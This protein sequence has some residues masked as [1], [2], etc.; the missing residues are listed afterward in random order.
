MW[1]DKRKRI[2]LIDDHM[3]VREGLERLLNAGD[4][5]VICEEAGNAAEGI[6]MVRAIRPDAVILDIGLP[7]GTDGIEVAEKL[8]S[9]FPEIV[10][11]ILSAHEEP[12]YAQ[13]AAQAGAMG[14]VLKSE[15]AETL[16]AALRNAFKGIR[17]FSDNVLK[18]DRSDFSRL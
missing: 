15:A 12:E 6:E 7:G 13:R 4:E 1:G 2:V 9:E 3:L 17:T 5:F 8:W 16:R 18:Q 14:Y 10:V 11:L